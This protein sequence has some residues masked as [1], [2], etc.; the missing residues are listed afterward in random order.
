[1][2]RDFVLGLNAKMYYLRLNE[3]VASDGIKTDFA[4]DKATL[5]NNELDNVRDVTLNLETGQADVTTRGG[6]GWRQIVAT[7][8][9]GT[10]ETQMVWDPTDV[11]FTDFLT[12]W[13]AG[14]TIA[15]AILDHVTVP[16]S[17]EKVIGLYADFAITNFTRNEQLENALLADVRLN[18]GRGTTSPEWVDVLT[19]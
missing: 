17:G 1:M 15:V 13:L 18:V 8:K 7:L 14:R 6:S 2:A 3:G 19:P 16:P 12:A 5:V 9:S 11:G 10:V 4:T